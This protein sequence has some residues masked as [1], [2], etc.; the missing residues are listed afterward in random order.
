MATTT[1][2]R[3]QLRDEFEQ[4]INDALQEREIDPMT[5]RLESSPQSQPLPPSPKK[6]PPQ[7]AATTDAD[8]LA[9]AEWADKLRDQLDQ[10]WAN[11]Y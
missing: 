11:N 1:K 6:A 7:F 4:A 10:A 5:F 8:K 3:R 9:V 2:K